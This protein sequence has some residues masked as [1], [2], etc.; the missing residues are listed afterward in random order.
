MGFGGLFLRSE[1]KWKRPGERLIYSTWFHST[2]GPWVECYRF[3]SNNF[4]FNQFEG[5]RIEI[6]ENPLKVL[7]EIFVFFII[8]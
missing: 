7:W 8:V 1:I 2:M 6:S 5:V 4:L 3:G